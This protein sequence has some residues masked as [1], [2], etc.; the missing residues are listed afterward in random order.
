MNLSMWTQLLNLLLVF[1]RHAINIINVNMGD[2]GMLSVLVCFVFR[3][4]IE[5]RMPLIPARGRQRQV[6]LDARLRFLIKWLQRSYFSPCFKK[7]ELPQ[8]VIWSLSAWNG[9]FLSYGFI[10]VLIYWWTSLH[11]CHRSQKHFKGYFKFQSRW[12]ERT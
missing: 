4:G 1:A 11:A 3:I 5:N 9:E 7:R 12:L 6:L 10:L 2:K 8:H